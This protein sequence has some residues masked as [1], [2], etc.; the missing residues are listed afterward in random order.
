MKWYCLTLCRLFDSKELRELFRVKVRYHQKS[1][2]YNGNGVGRIG[3]LSWPNFEQVTTTSRGKL[4]V[5]LRL[6][7]PLKFL[8]PTN[9][10]FQVK[11]KSFVELFAHSTN[12]AYL[13]IC[14][15]QSWSDWYLIFCTRCHMKS[16]LTNNR[17]VQMVHYGHFEAF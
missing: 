5:S 3:F 9:L 1:I 14:C 17:H 4:K 2:S 15:V 16:P 7:L 12:V 13:W 6:I 11:K 10:L 8:V